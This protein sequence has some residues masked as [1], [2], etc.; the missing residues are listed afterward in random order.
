[1]L[2]FELER[3]ATLAEAM[4]LLQK[5]GAWAKNGGTDLL[6]WM[7]KHAVQPKLVVD[8]SLIDELH[9]IQF[10]PEEGLSVGACVTLNELAYFSKARELYPALVDAAMSHSDHII[11]NKATYVGNIC[12]SVPSGDMIP[13]TCVYEGVVHVASHEGVRKVPILEFITGPRRNVLKPGEVVTRITLP[14]PEGPSAGC[15]IKLGRRNALDLAQVGVACLVT[16]GPSG[17][18]YRLSYGAV[19]PVPVRAVRAEALLDGASQV[20]AQLMAR[21]CEEAKG[22]VN[23]ITDVRASRE[24]RLSMVGELTATAISKCLESL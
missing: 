21:V 3:P 10:N 9:G 6:V 11:R 20:D 7:K 16:D 5:E 24:Y 1:M 19:S 22:A 17:R 8:L 12:S 18:K 23:P 4:K 14:V 15:Y 13:P 2:S